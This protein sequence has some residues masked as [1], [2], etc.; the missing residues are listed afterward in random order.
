MLCSLVGFRNGKFPDVI[1]CPILGPVPEVNTG[2]C[3]YLL[4][5]ISMKGKEHWRGVGGGRKTAS[6]SPSGFS[7]TWTHRGSTI[8][9]K[10]P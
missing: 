6:K 3:E 10:A 1:V 2:M 9:L 8:Q 4:E 5:S 7:C